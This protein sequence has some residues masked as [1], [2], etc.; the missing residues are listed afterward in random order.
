M[1]VQSAALALGDWI[2]CTVSQPQPAHLVVQLL[3]DKSLAYGQQL[4]ADPASGWKKSS[5]PP[6]ISAPVAEANSNG[7]DTSREGW[8]L[9]EIGL[10]G[11]VE[12]QRDDEMAIFETDEDAVDHVKRMAAQGSQ[13]HKDALAR[14]LADAPHLTLPA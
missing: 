1:N 2:E 9:F 14:H 7:E 4:L 11:L 6:A 10:S 3:T 13:P 12:I 5:P 8:A